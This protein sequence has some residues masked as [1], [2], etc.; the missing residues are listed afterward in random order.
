MTRR[1]FPII[2][3][4]M[5]IKRCP[6]CKAIIDENAEYCSNC[7][8]QLLFPEDEFIEEEIPGEKILDEKEKEIAPAKEEKAKPKKK[9]TSPLKKTQAALGLT[10]DEEEKAE[11]EPIEEIPKEESGLAEQENEEPEEESEEMKF[12][13]SDADEAKKEDEVEVTEQATTDEEINTE[14]DIQIKEKEEIQKMLDRFNEEKELGKEDSLQEETGVPRRKKR[15]TQEEKIAPDVKE[16]SEEIKRTEE[17]E[18][19]TMPDVNIVVEEEVEEA[20]DIPKMKEFKPPTEMEHASHTEKEMGT[21]DEFKEPEKREKLE[22]I[23]EKVESALLTEDTDNLAKELEQPAAEELEE[24]IIEPVSEETP[25]MPEIKSEEVHHPEIESEIKEI[26]GPVEET[27]FGNEGQDQ[28]EDMTMKEEEEIDRFMKS[29]KEEREAKGETPLPVEEKELSEEKEP[30]F[31]PPGDVGELL[32]DDLMKMVEPASREVEEI[33]EILEPLK[34]E[35]Q[36]SERVIPETQDE[37]PPWA[38]EIKGAGSLNIPVEEVEEAEVE[39]EETYETDE[40]IP[41]TELRIDQEEIPATETSM[42]IPETVRQETLPFN[43]MDEEEEI[44]GQIRP[45]LQTA[46]WLKSRVFDTLFIAG[47][48]IISLWIASRVLE[49]SLFKMVSASVLPVFAFFAI[50][51]ISYFFLFLYFLGETLGDQIFSQKG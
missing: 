47:I 49:I 42:G 45:P 37:L 30:E 43:T 24:P 40:E 7:G 16:K 41:G 20:P 29:V 25:E 10:E 8:T 1:N 13:E 26:P 33:E 34:E 22:S 21:D 17:L 39:K 15:V 3:R 5:A 2:N 12:K 31:L 35:K 46:L 6:Y 27:D 48:W 9:T 50:L 14:S 44:G 32:T 11:E 38:S 18:L 36:E 19:E 4:V 23:R 28:I 51:L